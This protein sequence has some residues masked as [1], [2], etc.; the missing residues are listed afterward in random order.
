MKNVKRWYPCARILFDEAKQ[1]AVEQPRCRS[2]VESGSQPGGRGW[3]LRPRRGGA[4]GRGCARPLDGRMGDR[5]ESSRPDGLLLHSADP[6]VT[7]KR[8][9]SVQGAVESWRSV[10]RAALEVQEAPQIPGAHCRRA[11]RIKISRGSFLW[12]Q[13]CR[14]LP[15]EQESAAE[16]A[17]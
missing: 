17:A 11:H 13:P 10:Q 15:P 8:A 6:S 16:T 9:R 7:P 3:P 14:D 12:G 1:F 2:D 5:A 4:A